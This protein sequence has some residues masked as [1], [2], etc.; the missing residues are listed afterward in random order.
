MSRFD[1]RAELASI[2]GLVLQ[3][4]LFGLFIVLFSR[5]NSPATLAAGWHFLCGAGVWLLI[6]IELYQ[7]RLARQQRQELEGLERE[8]LGRL[9]GS[10]SVFEG[11][12]PDE[13]LTAER[14][15]AL[16]KRWLVP[17][18]SLLI[19]GLL[20]LLA[21]RSI[22]SLWP[23]AWVSDALEGAIEDQQSTLAFSAGSA[24]LCFLISR[25]VLGLSKTSGWRVLRAGANYIMGNALVCFALTIVLALS[26][27]SDEAEAMPE[28]VLAW[29]IPFVMLVLAAEIV[30]NLV[31]DI[32]R[33]RVPGEEYRPIYESRLLGLFSEPEGVM[34]SIAHTIDYQFGFNVS[35]T[36]FYQLLQ[37][38]VIP[39]FLFGAVVLYSLSTLVI[40]GTGSQAVVTRFGAEPDKVLTAGLH[41]KWPW[42]VEKVAYY[43]V[44]QVQELVIGYEGRGEWSFE[45]ADADAAEHE[46]PILW[47]VAH[48]EEKEFQIL[49]ASRDQVPADEVGDDGGGDEDEDKRGRLSP[50]NILAGALAVKYNVKEDALLDYVRH[51]SS[52][53]ELLEAVTYRLW[54]EYMASVDPIDVMTT[55]SGEVG[56]ALKASIQAEADR[57]GLGLNILAVEILG[58]HPPV[59]VAGAFEAAINAIQE[60]ETLILQAQGKASELVPQARAEA[61][62]IIA[63]AVT[64]RDSK[65]V[66]ERARAGLFEE[67]L[68]SYRVAPEV[69]KLRNYLHV[70][71]PAVAE[72]RK[73]VLA[74]ADPEKIIFIIDEKEK[75]P[76]DLLDLAGQSVEEVRK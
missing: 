6:L 11:L 51:Y 44:H 15:L 64:D 60:K 22:P 26:L 56:V 10:Q 30:L 76:A 35:E 75:L 72:A 5:S 28:R 52:P 13:V 74:V 24:L 62:G 67:Q 57:R 65:T 53:R 48:V 47:T 50:V 17:I 9:G 38:A 18:F 39:L 14:R 42:P 31:L 66:I 1:K 41:F 58:I 37:R 19:A 23:M 61:A 20:G 69:F 32:Y 63:K 12:S 16:V 7:Q 68:K 70:I 73:Y 49:V 43:P 29:V 21:I 55:G 46:A 36:W 2:I 34:R 8:R 71:L 25:I 4:V 27:Y 33:P 54:T 3:C 45:E 40:V 59:E